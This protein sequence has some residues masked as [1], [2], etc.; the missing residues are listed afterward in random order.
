MQLFLKGMWCRYVAHFVQQTDEHQYAFLLQDSTSVYRAVV[1]VD[2]LKELSGDRIIISSLWLACSTSLSPCDFDLWGNLIKSL[3]IKPS[4]WRTEGSFLSFPR[5]T[6]TC[7]CKLFSEMSGM[8][9]EQC[10]A[11]AVFSSRLGKFY[12][13]SVGCR[14]IGFTSCLNLSWLFLVCWASDSSTWEV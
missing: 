5:R 7:E 11:F 9:V 8:C 3:Q 1:F 14:F 2:A 6:A 13:K 12:V 10:R 4:C